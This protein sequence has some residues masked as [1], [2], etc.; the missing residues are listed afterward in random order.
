MSAVDKIRN[1]TKWL[2]TGTMGSKIYQFAF[3][4]VLAR[5]L[6]PADFGIMVTIQIFTGIAGYFSGA[7]MGQ[8]LVQVRSIRPHYYNIV[9]TMQMCI[10]VLIYF[11]FY[12]IAP[13]FAVYFENPMYVPLLRVAA[14]SFLWRPFLSI[15]NAMLQRQMR[16]K[17]I[18]IVRLTV[19]VFTGI[20][21][22][23]MA[24]S[25]Y[26]VWSLILG[27]MVGSVL[28]ILILF[29]VTRW[30]PGIRFE[31]TVA[32]QLGTYGFKVSANSI[33]SYFGS[34][35]DN[36]F[37]SRVLGPQA[38][39]LYNKGY[40]LS[41]MPREIISKSTYNVLFRAFSQE[42]DNLD[43]T[44]YVYYKS[45]MLVTVYTAPI[46]VGL[47]WIADPFIE[48][49]YGEKWLA[50]VPVLQILM[51][52]GILMCVGNISGAVI[53]A[54][55]RLGKEFT[56]MIESLTLLCLGCYFFISKGIVFVAMVV[57]VRTVYSIVRITLFACRLID[58]KIS[59]LLKSIFPGLFFSCIMLFLLFLLDIG[60]E[61]MFR[62]LSKPL[63]LFITVVF[64]AFVYSLSFLYI[65]VP[66]LAS[67][68]LKWKIRFK[69]TERENSF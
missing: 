27:G 19:P 18:S 49:V 31:F 59:T 53:E 43:M 41:E 10:G 13:W 46:F 5:I 63:Y 2:F 64:G 11:L 60:L 58:A 40:S 12:L 35:V 34:Q 52:K 15:Q 66:S 36:I 7:G 8:A 24:L 17:H 1:S 68:V 21:S 67:E 51:L 54:Q 62:D 45:I 57:L 39:G 38:L 16:F 50:C 6:V 44:R 37:V 25:G 14:V 69:L 9:F 28:Q 32:R 20:I 26:G 61:T 42:Q 30:R 23:G 65:P 4:V 33:L 47:W 48:V 55:N 3:G 29:F 56:I 22:I